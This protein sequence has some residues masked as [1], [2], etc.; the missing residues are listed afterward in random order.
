MY[1]Y[2]VWTMSSLENDSESQTRDIKSKM[3][4]LDDAIT[5]H[6]W[7]KLSKHESFKVGD[8]VPYGLMAEKYCPEIYHNCGE[9]F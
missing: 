4:L 8:Q 5:I 3:D 6:V 1:T 2:S 7:N 9:T